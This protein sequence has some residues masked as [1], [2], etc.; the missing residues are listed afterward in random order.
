MAAK[1]HR[2]G[3]GKRHS[4]GGGYRKVWFS[5]PGGTTAGLVLKSSEV[6]EKTIPELSRLFPYTEASKMTKVHASPEYET[7]D[8]AFKHERPWR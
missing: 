7:W 2:A 8:Q 4:T 6:D 1:R 5:G 3:K